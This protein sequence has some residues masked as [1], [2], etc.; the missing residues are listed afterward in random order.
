[1]VLSRLSISGCCDT[2]SLESALLMIVCD[3]CR[4]EIVALGNKLEDAVFHLQAD[5][6]IDFERIFPIEAVTR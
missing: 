6:G 2:L 3:A 4:Q 5:L 1:M